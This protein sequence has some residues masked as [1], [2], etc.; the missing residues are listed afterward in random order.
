MYR[1]FL[2]ANAFCP[3]CLSIIITITI[4]IIIIIINVNYP[5]SVRGNSI[6]ASRRVY[7][8]SVIGDRRSVN[9]NRSDRQSIDHKIRN[10][11]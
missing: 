11:G 1:V 6:R 3:S 9:G 2:C 7:C 5:A 4:I 10:D 8:M